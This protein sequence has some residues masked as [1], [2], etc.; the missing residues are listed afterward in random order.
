MHREKLLCCWENAAGQD[1]SRSNGTKTEC[2]SCI[3]RLDTLY[4]ERCFH[5]FMSVPCTVYCN[6]VYIVV[7]ISLCIVFV[8]WK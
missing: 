2:A 1:S 6:F 3:A 4:H 7:C 5:E 8:L